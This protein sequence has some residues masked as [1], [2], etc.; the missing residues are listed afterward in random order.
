M[1]HVKSCRY[2]EDYKLALQF[3]NGTEGIVDLQ[4]LPESGTVFAPL[5]DKGCFHPTPQK[6]KILKPSFLQT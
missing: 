4:D 3:D 1:L 5:K 2:A 6:C